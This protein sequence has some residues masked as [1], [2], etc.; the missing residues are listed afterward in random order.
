MIRYLPSTKK[1]VAANPKA[2]CIRGVVFDM[3]GTL[4]TSMTEHLV[5]MRRVINVPDGMRTLEYVDTCLEGEEREEAHRRIIEIETDAMAHM[6]LSPGLV[7]LM[8]FLYDNDIRTAVITRNSRLAVDHLLNNVISKQPHKHKGLFK[9]DPILDRSFKPTKPSPDSLLHV[10]RVWGIPPEQ[11]MMVG[12]HGDD[13][14]CGV[15]AGSISALLR[16]PD[17][18]VF[19]SKAHVVVDRISELVEHLSNGFDVDMSITGDDDVGV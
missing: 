7:E 6:E 18:R 5:M 1:D 10:S 14:L 16:Y 11:L 4:T 3:D 19:E 15:R 9:F 2:R 12:D 13:L 8:E 17:N